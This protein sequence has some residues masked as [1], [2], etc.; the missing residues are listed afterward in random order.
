MLGLPS[1][2]VKLMSYS[3]SWRDEFRREAEVILAVTPDA[4]AVQH[5]GSTAIVGL[6][7]K[8]I[9][10]LLVGIPQD[11]NTLAMT[12]REAVISHFQH[13]GYTYSLQG[14]TDRR[15][16]FFRGDAQ[17]KTHHLHVVAMESQEWTNLLLFRDYLRYHQDARDAYAR[18]KKQLAQQFSN[19]REAYTAAKSVFIEAVLDQ[20]GRENA[21]HLSL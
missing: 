10:D 3:P 19:D 1:G 17:I 11:G 8:P 21:H 13:I 16:F 14:S 7:A 18:L 2:T 12:R 6:D 9:I 15:I 20:A 5:I 4:V